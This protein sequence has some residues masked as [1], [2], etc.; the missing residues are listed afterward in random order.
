MSYTP[1]G[2]GEKVGSAIG[3]DKRRIRGDLGRFRE[4]IEGWQAETGAWRGEIKGGTKTP[5]DTTT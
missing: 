4:L 1:E 3:L 2:L 5:P